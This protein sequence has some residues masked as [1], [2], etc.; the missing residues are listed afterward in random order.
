MLNPNCFKVLFVCTQN[1]GRSQMAAELFNK[2]TEKGHA[3]SVG[4]KVETPGATIEARAK[5]SEGAQNIL[6]VMSEEGLDLSKNLQ[7]QITE[8]MLNMYD[9]IVVMAEPETIPTYLQT[10]SKFEYWDIED[11]RFKGLEG[12]RN[13]KDEIKQKVLKLLSS[14]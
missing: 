14:V 12:T 10:N 2:Y 8:V 6:T 1:R 4:T 13:T 11:P 9:K 5:I 3:D 7:T